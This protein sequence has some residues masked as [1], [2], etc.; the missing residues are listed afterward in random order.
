MH[1][2]PY[3]CHVCMEKVYIQE[4]IECPRCGMPF[5]EVYNPEDVELEE[6]SQEEEATV[7]RRR[8]LFNALFNVFERPKPRQRP[9]S[10]TADRRNYAI[11]PE[12]HDIITRLREEKQ[13][14]ENPATGEQKARL[15]AK[16]PPPGDTCMICLNEFSPGEESAEYPC[17]HVF[18][19]ACSDAWLNLQSECPICRTSL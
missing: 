18:H 17:Q 3:F 14:E 10:I 9:E 5:I 2:L 12:I 1:D 4:R 19:G 8:S 6:Y 15:R 13:I 7:P 16:V 11:G